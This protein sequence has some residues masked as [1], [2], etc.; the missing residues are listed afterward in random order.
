MSQIEKDN[1]K[2]FYGRYFEEKEA[3]IVSDF[4]Q[5]ELYGDNAL[6]NFEWNIDD[7]TDEYKKVIDKYGENT[8]ERIT[9]HDQGI[10]QNKI[11]KVHLNMLVYL[12]INVKANGLLRF[13]K[14]E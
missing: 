12:S 14:I 9:K 3:A 5:Y 2:Y 1:K 7:L 13:P 11:K 8:S 6:Y 10:K 4:K